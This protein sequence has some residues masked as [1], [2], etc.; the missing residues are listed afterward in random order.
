MNKPSDYEQH[1]I[2]EIHVWK[3]PEIGWFGE[4]MNFGADNDFDGHGA[5]PGVPKNSSHHAFQKTVPC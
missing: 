1:A 4:A 3:N 5:S 2:R